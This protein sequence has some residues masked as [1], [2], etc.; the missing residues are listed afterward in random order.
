MTPHAPGGLLDLVPSY[1]QHL[2]RRQDIEYR[3]ELWY[4]AEPFLVDVWVSA[5]GTTSFRL[6][7]AIRTSAD[8]EPAVTAEAVI[9]LVDLETG[10]PWPIPSEIG[11]QFTGSVIPR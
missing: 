7:S 9:V 6:G 5:V 1:I 8:A 11:G 2:V 3:D 10:K 4:Q